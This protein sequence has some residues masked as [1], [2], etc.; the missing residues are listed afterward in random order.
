MA[1]SDNVDLDASIIRT[2]GVIAAYATRDDRP[3]FPFRP[4][5]FENVT[6]RLLGSDDF[7]AEAKERAARDLTAAASGALVVP[8]A[9]VRPLEEIAAAHDLV[10]AGSRARILVNTI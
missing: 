9:D 5:L 3:G 2:G 4:M 6:I 10:D 7:P 1:F 8:V